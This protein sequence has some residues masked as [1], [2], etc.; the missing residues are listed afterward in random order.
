MR[1]IPSVAPRVMRVNG[2]VFVT[3]AVAA[4]AGSR[5]GAQQVFPG[6]DWPECSITASETAARTKVK[7]EFAPK[8][9]SVRLRPLAPRANVSFHFR[10]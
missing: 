5:P 9:M 6:I 4:D 3:S 8:P 1:R 10:P 2:S 7:V